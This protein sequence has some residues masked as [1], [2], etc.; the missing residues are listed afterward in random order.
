MGKEVIIDLYKTPY[1]N[2][3]W[4]IEIDL[5]GIKENTKK[6]LIIEDWKLVKAA[7]LYASNVLGLYIKSLKFRSWY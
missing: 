5:P 3:T 2:I 4:K 7:S 6:S 1:I